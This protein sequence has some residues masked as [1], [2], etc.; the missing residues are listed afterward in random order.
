MYYSPRLTA[1]ITGVV[2]LLGTSTASRGSVVVGDLIKFGDSVGSPGG[3]FR[4]DVLNDAPQWNFDSFCVE[5]EDYINFST[6]YV[7]AN[8]GLTTDRGNRTLSSFTAWLYNSYLDQ[9]LDNFN[10]AATN[11]TDAN[12]LQFAIWKSM[13]YSESQ[14]ES[15]AGSSS[16]Y[17]DYDA[18]LT[19]K[20]WANDFANDANW[21]GTG[22][23]FVMS[24]RRFDSAGQYTG[25]AQDQIVRVQ[26][27]TPEPMSFV[28]WTALGLLGVMIYRKQL[29]TA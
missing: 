28:I 5:L 26:T 13:G 16:W 10:F 29:R 20:G 11:A 27:H 8:I 22:D 21:S 7:V 12:A 25:Y 14:I 18:L 3:V 15:A 4:V 19:S 23:I 9:T 1:L 6:T 24:L 17:N 2:L